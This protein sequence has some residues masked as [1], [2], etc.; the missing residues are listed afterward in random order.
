MSLSISQSK[1][2]EFMQVFGQDCPNAPMTPPDQIRELRHKLIREENSEYMVDSGDLVG[3]ADAIGD[4]LYVVLGAAV[5]HGIDIEPIFNEIHRSNMTKLWSKREI[6]DVVDGVNV[7]SLGAIGSDFHNQYDVRFAFDTS[8]TMDTTWK[9]YVVRRKD[10][11]VIKS[12]SYEPA[13]L[14][15]IIAAQRS[16]K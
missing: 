5:A 4:L 2:R 6:S 10:G 8:V 3:A 9:Q 7:T 11:K 15:P 1:V 13:N 16:R 12:P 14:E